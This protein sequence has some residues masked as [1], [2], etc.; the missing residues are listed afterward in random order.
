MRN[1]V[2]EKPTKYTATAQLLPVLV[3]MTCAYTLIILGFFALISDHRVIHH[4][5]GKSFHLWKYGLLNVVL[6]VFTTVSYVYWQA[7]GEGARARAMVL[8]ILFTALSFWGI[9]LGQHLAKSAA[10]W[11]VMEDRFHVLFSFH[12]ACTVFDGVTAVL[13][14]LHEA[15]LGRAMGADLTVYPRIDVW[16]QPK[17]PDQMGAF[18]YHGVPS[19]LKGPKQGHQAQ[20]KPTAGT[21]SQGA[22]PTNLSFGPIVSEYDKIM[23][24]TQGQGG[25]SSILPQTEP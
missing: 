15:G 1:I 10:C 25:S 23:E 7:G 12:H 14:M 9:L 17:P 13:L 20:M 16:P 11:Q 8:C 24:K 21:Y 19:G 6:W 5:C 4:D 3:F 2:D 22:P 18:D